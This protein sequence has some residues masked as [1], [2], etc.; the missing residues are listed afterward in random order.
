MKRRLVLTASAAACLLAAC[1]KESSPA[2]GSAGASGDK[3]ASQPVSVEA[4]EQKAKG[5]NVGSTMA[6]RVLYVFFD[7]QCPHCAV[8]WEN[9]KPLKSQVRIVWIPVGL[10]GDKSVA[11]GAAILSAPDPVTKMEENEAS[12]RNQQGGIGAMGVEDAQKEIIKANTALF[13]SF[14][15]SGVPTIVGKHAQTGGVVTIDGAV[16]AVTLAQKFGLTAPGG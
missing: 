13:T 2:G 8:L 5:F 3:P 1:G 10:I 16:P 6:T 11:Q 7:P 9:V 14:G 12:V 4:I 15:F